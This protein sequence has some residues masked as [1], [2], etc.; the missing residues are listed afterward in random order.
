MT[1]RRAE[2]VG[3]QTGIK[4][5]ARYAKNRTE[6]FQ[7]IPPEL[8]SR[9]LRYAHGKSPDDLLFRIPPRTAEMLRFDLAK[10]GIPYLD[11]R[12]KVFDFHALRGES[13]S[14]LLA[15]GANVKEVQEHMRHSDI[16][17]TMHA[18][19]RILKQ[20][21]DRMKTIAAGIAT[22]LM[23]GGDGHRPAVNEQAPPDSP[24]PNESEVLAQKS[25]RDPCVTGTFQNQHVLTP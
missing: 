6:A 10:A 21:R 25:L 17:L 3:M 20:G 7:S 13:G 8:A 22:S 14:L 9:L 24:G 2:L 19:A 4:I 18:Y 12:G 15:N 1:V 11:A 23:N 5:E 16:K